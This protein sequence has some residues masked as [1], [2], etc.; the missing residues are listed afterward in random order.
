[1]WEGECSQTD[2]EVPTVPIR[3]EGKERGYVGVAQVFAWSQHGPDS[4]GVIG[5]ALAALEKHLY[6]RVYAR[7]D[8]KPLVERLL[9]EIHS[10]AIVGVLSV[11]GRRHPYY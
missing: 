8:V 9:T 7:D 2:L 6:D 5:S 1:M 11:F 4:S 10:L 3:V